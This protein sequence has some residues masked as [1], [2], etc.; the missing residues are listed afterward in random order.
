MFHRFTLQP[1]VDAGPD[2]I[3]CDAAVRRKPTGKGYGFIADIHA[4]DQSAASGK[5]QTVLPGIALQVGDAQAAHIAQQGELFRKERCAAP[6]QEARL[7]ELMAVVRPRGGV[8]GQTVGFVQIVTHGLSRQEKDRFPTGQIP[9]GGR[10][11][12]GHLSVILALLQERV[13][14][15]EQLCCRAVP[16]SDSCVQPVP[17][18]QDT[19]AKCAGRPPASGPQVFK[20]SG[21]SGRWRSKSHQ[22]PDEC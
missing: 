12:R 3:R 18:G 21:R 10:P 20:C 5:T 9:A 4:G 17:G 16:F 19:A 22:R 13:K 15:L 14:F 6:A 11:G 2:E 7:I 1:V 8:P